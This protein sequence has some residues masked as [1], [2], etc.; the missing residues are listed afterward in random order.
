VLVFPRLVTHYKDDDVI[1]D[2]S[3]IEFGT[4]NAYGT[5][6]YGYG[7]PGGADDAGA[8]FK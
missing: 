2:S 7:A 5:D 6:P 8:A 4:G 3:K 1:V